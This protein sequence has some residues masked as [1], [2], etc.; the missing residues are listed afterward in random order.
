M[1]LKWTAAARVCGSSV[2][3]CFDCCASQWTEN[4]VSLQGAG[5]ASPNAAGSTLSMVSI[6][7]WLRGKDEAVITDVGGPMAYATIMCFG[8]PIAL[9]EKLVTRIW[10]G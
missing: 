10:N 5:C 6:G 9:A 1:G 8:R 4:F 2:A 3:V 7:E